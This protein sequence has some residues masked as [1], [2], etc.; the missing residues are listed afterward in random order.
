MNKENVIIIGSGLAA[1]TLANRLV[2][3]KNVI[4]L[5]KGNRDQNNSCKAQGGI[6]AAVSKSDNWKSHMADT[7]TAGCQ[8]NNKQAVRVLV[9]KGPNLIRDLV[10]QGLEFDHDAQGNFLLGREGAHHERRILHAG[11]DATGKVLMEF[12]HAQLVDKVA[13]KEGETV[14]DLLVN[15]G[16]CIGVIT[17][18][19]EGERSTYYAQHTILA[20]GGCGALYQVTSNDSSVAGDGLALAYRAGASLSDLEFIQFHPTMLYIN[21]QCYGLVSEAVRGEGAIL[22][23]GNGHNIMKGVHVLEDLAPRDVVAREIQ[24]HI[25]KGENVYLDI[26]MIVNFE[27]KF[28]TITQLC[29][30]AN[31]DLAEAKIPV[32]PGAHFHMGGVKTNQLGETTLPGLYAIGEVACNGVHGA[33]RLASNSLLEGIVFSNLLAEHLLTQTN[34]QLVRFKIKDPSTSAKNKQLVLPNASDLK[35]LMTD[36][37]GIERNQSGLMH[38]K[39][40]LE[41]YDFLDV[42]SLDIPY[43]TNEEIGIINR[44]TCCWLIVTSALSRTESRGGHFRSDFPYRDSSRWGD[45]QIIRNNKEVT[46][47]EEMKYIEVGNG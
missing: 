27:E 30:S 1:L 13:I 39:Q 34:A 10:E 2:N 45:Q 5:T 37:V 43:L 11:G 26:S 17:S 15:N 35:K 16:R 21:N 42:N 12:M 6:A 40:W 18:N 23:T 41:K 31:I 29:E 20:T 36:Y 47:F 9:Q 44:L 14:I 33:N 22:K 3:F 32:A 7:M 4:L 46:R 19:Q 8:Y 28:P 24:K 25:S 38:A